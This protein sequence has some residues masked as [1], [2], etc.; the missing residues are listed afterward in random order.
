MDRDTKHR[1]RI[2]PTRKSQIDL[3][4]GRYTR[5]PWEI[6]TPRS[7]TLSSFK[8]HATKELA[9]TAKKL[10]FIIVAY[11]KPYGF[12]SVLENMRH[13][14]PVQTLKTLRN[15]LFNINPCCPWL[16]DSALYL[17]TS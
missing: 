15:F 4:F 5:G 3:K 10:G 12:D 8:E 13:L 16:S 9:A 1:L 17:W 11:R 2:N 14:D 6:K 7:G